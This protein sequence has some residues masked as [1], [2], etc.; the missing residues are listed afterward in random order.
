MKFIITGGGTGGH[1]YPAVAITEEL[2]K[3]YRDARFLYIGVRGRAEE[4]L[5][6]RLG[7]DIRYVVGAGMT[8][9]LV[10][11][12]SCLSGIKLA[13][14]IVQAAFI[15]LSFKP[16]AVIGTGGYA[17]V[18]AVMAAVLLRGVGLSRCKVFIHEQNYAP[19]RWNSL[20]ARWVNRVWVSFEGSRRFFRS[21]RV[22]LT[23]Y[24]VRRQIVPIDKQ[25]ARKRLGI[26]P[27]SK[28]VF[29][30][31][32][33]QGARS[34]NRAL[35]DALPA[36][37]SNQG[38]EIF[39][40]TGAMKAE[41]YDAVA[42][43]AKRVAALGLDQETLGRY[44][45]KDFFHE[46]QDYYAAA[47]L[48]VC[49]AGAGTLNEI[50]RC[51][52]PALVI[53]KS[54]LAG[55][56]Q[57]IN[58]AALA[59]AGACEI[60]FERPVIAGGNLEASVDSGSLEKAIKGLL[61]DHDK[62]GALA[63]AA[64]GVSEPGA[65]G[66][67]ADSVKAELDGKSL[68][69]RREPAG[70]GTHQDE[71]DPA[72][73]ANLSP[74]GVLA[75]SREITAGKDPC[76]IESHPMVRM[77]RCFADGYL[78]SRNWRVRNTGIKLAGILRY[79]ERRNILLQVASDHT[80]ARLWKRLIYP[81]FSQVGFIRRNALVSLAGLETWDEAFR[82]VLISALTDD[83]Y[84]EVRV[85]AAIAVIRLRDKIGSCERLAEALVQ[86]LEHRSF[87]VRW[88]VLEALGAVAPR[89][90]FMID[91]ACHL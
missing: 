74:A 48:V 80:P 10:S 33:S 84:Y 26:R 13:T 78:V 56:H 57:M 11:S 66:I 9:G 86:N 91:K 85:Q 3:E 15:H 87:E 81:D 68:S 2:K 73:L 70:M 7:Y 52:C 41:N 25:L 6:P 62:L 14:G 90:D 17:S 64:A 27:G 35:A 19:G 44:H 69:R 46:I 32:G 65:M 51:A 61:S 1:V 4:S 75:L 18:P 8:G 39:H 58:A 59:R 49:R 82:K 5:I 36:L 16:D 72:R 23:G 67:F 30:F 77:L 20:I 55:E 60:V 88:S 76:I 29:V 71:F 34:I 42:D 79:H 47:D 31:G 63:K 38:I 45:P 54:N 43:T 22:E 89:A 83:P 53:P 40:G 50:C 37:L 21:C 28:T 12:G 24:P